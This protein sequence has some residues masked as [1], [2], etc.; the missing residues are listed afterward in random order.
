M[1][2]QLKPELFLLVD[3]LFAAMEISLLEARQPFGN[4][5]LVAS[6][7]SMIRRLPI[8]ANELSSIP[9]HAMP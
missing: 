2:R 5:A 7:T 1:D 9:Y 3:G 8:N 6:S 4:A